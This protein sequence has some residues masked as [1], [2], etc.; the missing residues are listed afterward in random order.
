MKLLSIGLPDNQEQTGF[1]ENHLKENLIEDTSKE[2]AERD[3]IDNIKKA[4]NDSLILLA[5][6]G[7]IVKIEEVP[8]G[9]YIFLECHIEEGEL[10]F[11]SYERIKEVLRKC[12]ADALADFI[13]SHRE[14]GIIDKIIKKNTYLSFE[15][16]EIL[17]VNTKKTLNEISHK[18]NKFSIERKDLISQ[19]VLEYLDTSHEL[20]LDGFIN[21]RLKDY[22]K[23]LEDV[24]EA[25]AND[26]IMEEEYNEF[27]R[28]LRYFVDIQPP[29]TE[30]VHVVIGGSETFKILDKSGNLIN[31]EY[32]GNI[33]TKNFAP[34]DIE[35]IFDDYSSKDPLKSKPIK[36]KQT[37]FRPNDIIN[38][39]DALISVLITIA[40][41]NIMIHS[42]NF[43]RDKETIEAIKSVFT[44]RMI[45]CSCC[46]I[47][48]IEK[49]ENELNG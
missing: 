27:I 11:K 16:H 49:L 14:D 39:E 43:S 35:I 20:A 10:S 38:Y 17:T 22:W 34:Q 31:T 15:E 29:Q 4:F 19:A 23:T 1:K 48:R 2:C 24:I 7:F 6:D 44:D 45:V 33:V 40:P 47:C 37:E 18:N 12:V 3:G 21:F 46:E 41:N 36:F 42:S 32:L 30:E 25:T 13:I 5:C 8:K 28:I 26:F 9:K